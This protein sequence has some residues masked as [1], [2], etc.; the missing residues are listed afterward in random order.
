MQRW[1][2]AGADRAEREAGALT[3]PGAGLQLLHA[4]HGEPAHTSTHGA[5]LPFALMVTLL[6]P[7]AHRWESVPTVALGPSLQASIDVGP[8]GRAGPG[9]SP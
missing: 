7:D 3:L 8:A 6:W 1:Q 9:V 2:R 4:V 5:L